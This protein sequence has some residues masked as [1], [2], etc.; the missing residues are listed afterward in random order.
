MQ[1]IQDTLGDVLKKKWTGFGCFVGQKIV[2]HAHFSK[3]S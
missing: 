2:A 1:M 3:L